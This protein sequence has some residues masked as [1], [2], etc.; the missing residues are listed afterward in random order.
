LIIVG[1][2]GFT[3]RPTQNLSDPMNEWTSTATGETKITCQELIER[4]MQASGDSCDRMGSNQVCYGNNTLLAEL[5]TGTTSRFSQRGDMV[6]VTDL[7]RLAASPLS[8]ASEEWGIAVFK[9]MAN[10]PRSLP[11]E[12]I[13]MVVFGNTTLDN[14]SSNL[15][16]FYFSSTLGQIVC[17]QVP[18]DG[19]MITMA[20][21]SGIS[22]VING[23]EMTLMGNASLTATQN[24][25]M[26]VSMFS[27]SASIA[28]NGRQQI[29]TAGQSTR[30]DLGGPEGMTAIS[31][32]SPPYPLSPEGLILACT[33]TGSFCSQQEITP[34]S[35]LDAVATLLAQSGL[36][37]SA[38]PS[39]TPSPTPTRTRTA[40]PSRTATPQPPTATPMP[41]Y[42]TLCHFVSTNHYNEI[43][44]GVDPATGTTGHD[45]H[46]GDIIPAPAGGC[47]QP[48]EPTQEPPPKPTKKP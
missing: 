5:I 38:T 2:F 39:F 8:L 6:S 37:A 35:L 16:T 17:D 14:P 1:F 48:P 34:V 18:F 30:M 33:L 22:F 26:E 11:G 7:R 23:A 12:T 24:G 29:V 43:T 3:R 20:D 31:D 19:L 44:V 10:L 15:Q 28:V 41:V 25:A 47:P 27:G 4:A 21:G 45:N 42:V 9:V 32:P 13:T 46:P 40:T 36:G